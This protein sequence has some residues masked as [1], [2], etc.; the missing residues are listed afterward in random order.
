MEGG[1]LLRK[2]DLIEGM[3]I[4]TGGFSR[5]PFV[6]SDGTDSQQAERSR[7]LSFSV[8]FAL[9]VPGALG[10]GVPLCTLVP[11]DVQFKKKKK[12]IRVRGDCT[13]MIYSELGRVLTHGVYFLRYN[14]S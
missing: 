4:R 6:T 7:Q 14:L 8:A 5:I 12:K 10:P 13:C 11:R 2:G 9:N 3:G 1:S